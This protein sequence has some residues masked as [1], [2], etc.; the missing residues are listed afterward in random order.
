[1]AEN[2]KPCPWMRRTLL[3]MAEGRPLGL[4]KWYAAQHIKNCNQCTAT[5]R[6]LLQLRALLSSKGHTATL[7]LS[8]ERWE[9]IEKACREQNKPS[10]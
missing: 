1:M 5:Y 9:E 2:V 3:K 7:T 4:M 6:A 10:R 8:R